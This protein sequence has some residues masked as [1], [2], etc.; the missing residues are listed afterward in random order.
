M[1]NIPRDLR[2]TARVPVTNPVFTAVAMLT[3]AL[4]IGANPAI[5]TLNASNERFGPR[6]WRTCPV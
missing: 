3:L 1:G 5:F 2:Y 4:G 6:S